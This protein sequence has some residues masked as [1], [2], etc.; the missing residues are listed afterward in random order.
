MP[1]LFEGGMSASGA[2]G[3]IALAVVASLCLAGLVAFSAVAR[4][5]RH[6]VAWTVATFL[7]GVVSTGVGS[8]VVAALYVVVVVVDAGSR[9]RRPGSE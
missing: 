2:G 4:G 5:D 3:V 9:E 7:A 1:A 8:V 6:A